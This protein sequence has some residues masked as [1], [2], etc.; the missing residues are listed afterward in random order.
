MASIK[1]V[2]RGRKYR[3]ISVLASEE[4]PLSGGGDIGPLPRGTTFSV[5]TKLSGRLRARARAVSLPKPR[6]DARLNLQRLLAKYNNPRKIN[7]C[8]ICDN[9]RFRARLYK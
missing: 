4:N 2:Y 8:I 1:V 3:G 7:L 9:A 5:A 6:R